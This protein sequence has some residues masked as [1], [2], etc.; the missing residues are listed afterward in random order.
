[1]NKDAIRTYYKQ[2]RNNFSPNQI[3]NDSIK[4]ANQL[5]SLPIWKHQY[6]HVFLPIQKNNEID[7]TFLIPILHG[8]EKQIVV[9]KTNFANKSMQHYLLED[10]TLIK[11]NKWG[12][13]EPED[14]IELALDKIDVVFVPL[15]AYDIKGNRVG[16]GKGF[17]DSFLNNC[18]ENTLKIGLSLFAPTDHLIPAEIHDV[19][20]DYCITPDRIWQF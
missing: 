19:T 4:I 5:L 1:M 14:G 7:T 3:V 9:S 8:K 12:I 2:L 15:L 20:L 10:T 17:Y 16:Y 13:P 11:E 18:P 6:Y